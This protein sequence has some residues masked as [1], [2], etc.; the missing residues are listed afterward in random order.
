MKNKSSKRYKKLFDLVK[1]K[2]PDLTFLKEATKIVGKKTNKDKINILKKDIKTKE[3]KLSPKLIDTIS[4]V[5]KIIFITIIKKAII[6]T[7]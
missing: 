7:K 2:K 4:E 5:S 1:N 3:N 6:S